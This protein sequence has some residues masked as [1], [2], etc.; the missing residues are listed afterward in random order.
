MSLQQHRRITLSQDGYSKARYPV[1]TL[2]FIDGLDITASVVSITVE[3][4]INGGCSLQM[5]QIIA[6]PHKDIEDIFARVNI[7]IPVP[8]C[9]Y[10]GG[11]IHRG[12]FVC[13]HATLSIECGTL[14]KRRSEWRCVGSFTAQPCSNI[15]ELTPT[16][17]AGGLFSDIA[18]AVKHPYIGIG[19]TRSGNYIAAV[20]ADFSQVTGT[21]SLE[22]SAP[23]VSRHIRP[24]KIS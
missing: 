4:D 23:P 1:P 11:V 18:S 12:D 16:Q 9:F 13:S 15:A 14:S 24:L 10:S 5:D 2:V 3:T 20:P 6:G 8:V 19:R 7:G 21:E 22:Q 17:F